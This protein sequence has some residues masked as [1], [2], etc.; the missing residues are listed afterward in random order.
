MHREKWYIPLF[1]PSF[2]PCSLCFSPFLLLFSP[3]C[4]LLPFFLL[5]SFY[6]F[7]PTFTSVLSNLYIQGVEGVFVRLSSRSPKDAALLVPNFSDLYQ[8]EVEG[9]RKEVEDVEKTKSSDMAMSA[10]TLAPT[11]ETNTKLHAL[12]RV[13]LPSHLYYLPP[14]LSLSPSQLSLPCLTVSSGVHYRASNI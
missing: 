6:L 7:L 3:F 10:G 9:V 12:Y 13:Y 8:Q 14:L 4:C 1:P 11:S 2:F 5:L